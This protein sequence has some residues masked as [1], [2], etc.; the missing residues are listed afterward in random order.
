MARRPELSA[1][2]DFG[3]NLQQFALILLAEIRREGLMHGRGVGRDL[4][5]CKEQRIKKVD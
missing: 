2:R 4:R 3:Q 5:T 1:G